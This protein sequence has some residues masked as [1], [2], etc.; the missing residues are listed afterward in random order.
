MTQALSNVHP[1]IDKSLDE[2]HRK[3]V[4]SVEGVIESARG[5][6]HISFYL[7]RAA[8]VQS[9]RCD[10]PESMKE[11]VLEASRKRNTVVASGVISYNALGE[12][13]SV[14]VQRPLR[15]LRRRAELPTPAEMVGLAPDLTDDLDTEEYIKGMRNS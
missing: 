1:R 13:L 12:P 9:V 7:Q 6:S 15:V 4:G 8:S 10:F 2:V 11:E 3:S 5:S 14:D